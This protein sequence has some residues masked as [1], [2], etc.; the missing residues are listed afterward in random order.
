MHASVQKIRSTQRLMRSSSQFRLIQLNEQGHGCV[1]G[2]SY[3]EPGARLEIAIFLLMGGLLRRLSGHGVAPV[4]GGGL[5]THR[6]RLVQ[7][8][9]GGSQATECLLPPPTP[10]AVSRDHVKLLVDIELQ[11]GLALEGLIW[12]AAAET[13]QAR[14]LLRPCRLLAG[15]SARSV[16][17]TP[18]GTIL[19]RVWFLF[20]APSWHSPWPGAP[21]FCWSSSSTERYT[22]R[23]RGY[24]TELYSCVTPFSCPIHCL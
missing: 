12:A 6:L 14:L 24:F 1:V 5:I 19:E 4:G 22:H 23:P 3:Q 10:A 11:S 21:L 7:G 16:S 13:T 20:F 18:A 2:H 8:R 17:C 15:A 9:G